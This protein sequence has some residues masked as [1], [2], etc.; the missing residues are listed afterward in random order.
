MWLHRKKLALSS[1]FQESVE[2]CEEI[3][4]QK[5]LVEAEWWSWQLF[6]SMLLL[7]LSSFLAVLLWN[8]KRRESFQDI[9]CWRLGKTMSLRSCAAL[10][11]SPKVAPFTRSIQLFYQ[12]IK[13]VRRMVK[14]TIQL[15][16]TQL[17][18]SD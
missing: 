12:T 5:M 10:L 7:K 6:L 14:M 3:D 4:L 8:I 9:S 11:F 17:R 16:L 15:K 13:R 18:K 1:Q 2:W